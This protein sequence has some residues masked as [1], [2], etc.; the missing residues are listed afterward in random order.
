MDPVSRTSVVSMTPGLN[1]LNIKKEDI[2]G[3][4][5]PT[6][7]PKTAALRPLYLETDKKSDDD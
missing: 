5:T 3:A 1:L 4:S 7:K 2:G 6:R